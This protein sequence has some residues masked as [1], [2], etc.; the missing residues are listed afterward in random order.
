MLAMHLHYDGFFEE[1][2]EPVHLFEM[3]WNRL[4]L[5][6]SPLFHRETIVFG[7]TKETARLVQTFFLR[8]GD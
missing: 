3:K 4:I 7:N 1:L 6:P 5:F 2:W 8:L